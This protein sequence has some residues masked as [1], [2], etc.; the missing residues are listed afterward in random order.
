MPL[1]VTKHHAAVTWRPCSAHDGA[2]RFHGNDGVRASEKLKV[3]LSDQLY[4]G[5]PIRTREGADACNRLGEI[6]ETRTQRIRPRQ[7]HKLP[8]SHG[9][10]RFTGNES[11][12]NAGS[13][14]SR[15]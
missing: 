11:A 4:R 7:Q 13:D 12:E 15:S 10:S 9:S 6:A 5:E 14:R 1:P 3:T 8:A 2:T